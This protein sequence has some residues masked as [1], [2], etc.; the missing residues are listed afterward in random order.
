MGY[1]SGIDEAEGRQYGVDAAG[2]SRRALGDVKPSG[3]A[4]QQPISK[5]G[6]QRAVADNLG[7][8]GV[9]ATAAKRTLKDKLRFRDSTSTSRTYRYRLLGTHDPVLQLE[10][11]FNSN[12]NER[13]RNHG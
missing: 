6:A 7:N 12:E 11:I 8:F 13:N 3:T 9:T 2:I 1:R 5:G 4:A 10:L